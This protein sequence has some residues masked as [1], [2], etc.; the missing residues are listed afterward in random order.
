MSSFFRNVDVRTGAE[1]PIDGGHHR[2]SALRA[3]SLLIDSEEG[4]VRQVMNGPLGE[5][6][7][8]HITDVSGAGNN[9]WVGGIW[10]QVY[11]VGIQPPHGL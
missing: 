9:W 4:V 1:I 11:S 7:E 3:R 2:I 5:L 8:Q 6:F 10:L